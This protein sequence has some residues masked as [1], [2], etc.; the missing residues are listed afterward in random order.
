MIPDLFDS[1]IVYNSAIIYAVKTFSGKNNFDLVVLVIS[2]V[3]K[4]EFE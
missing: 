4:V 1:Y 2:S 3:I